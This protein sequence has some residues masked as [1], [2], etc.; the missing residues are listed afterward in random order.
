MHIITKHIT[1][2]MVAD[3]SLESQRKL[4]NKMCVDKLFLRKRMIS[5]IDDKSILTNC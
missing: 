4:G 5:D 2:C 3:R 1:E